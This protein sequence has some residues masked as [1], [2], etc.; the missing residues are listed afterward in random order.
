MAVPFAIFANE[1][2]TNAMKCALLEELARQD[3]MGQ[4]QS[5]Y[6]DASTERDRT[7]E[8]FDKDFAIPYH[9]VALGTCGGLLAQ[10]TIACTEATSVTEATLQDVHVLLAIHKYAWADVVEVDLPGGKRNL[11][12]DSLASALRETWEETGV[13]LLGYD[14]EVPT[15]LGERVSHCTREGGHASKHF[16]NSQEHTLAA[17]E[18]DPEGKINIIYAIVTTAK[19]S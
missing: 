6:A 18:V 17:A 13:N 8:A 9:L 1:Q 15:V 2:S 19:S 7:D 14:P 4:V 5:L 12:E 16:P 10:R 3:V 11:G